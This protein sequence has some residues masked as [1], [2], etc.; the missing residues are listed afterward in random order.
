MNDTV[1]LGIDIFVQSS[2]VWSPVDFSADAC[3]KSDELFNKLY[4]SVGFELNNKN[5]NTQIEIKDALL[6]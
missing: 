3:C 1:K 6:Y 4:R 2:P 5:S